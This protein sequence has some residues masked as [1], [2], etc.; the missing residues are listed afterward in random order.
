MFVFTISDIIGLA[1]FG[2]TV[3]VLLIVTLK[4]AV[5]QALCWHKKFYENSACNAICC[6]CG[7]NLGHIQDSRKH[8]NR[9]EVG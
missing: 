3:L 6:E 2:L 9:T 8:P 4:R 5:H 7:K 1:V